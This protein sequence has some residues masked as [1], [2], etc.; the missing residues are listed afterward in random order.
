VAYE[1]VRSYPARVASLI[2]SNTGTD[3]NK[4]LQEYDR[5]QKAD[6]SKFWKTHA[7]RVGMPEALKDAMQHGGTVWSGMDVVVD[8]KAEPLGSSPPTL[9]IQTRHDFGAAVSQNWRD[10]LS[11]EQEVLL[12]NCA[13]Y[14]HLEDGATFGKLVSDFMQRHETDS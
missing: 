12:D 8:Y 3:M 1:Y 11:I 4:T 7:C 2:L 6:P 5:L 14:P 10:L 13:H 9:L